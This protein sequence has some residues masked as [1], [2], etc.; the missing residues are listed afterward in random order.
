MSETGAE[1]RFR[2][3]ADLAP[4]AIFVLA[5]GRFVYANPAAV[6]A[7]GY[8]AVDELLAIQPSDC[9]APDA[10]AALTTRIDCVKRGALGLRD[11]MARRKDG[12]TMIMEISSSI[13]ELEGLEAVLAFG[14]DVTERRMLEVRVEQ[15]DRLATIGTLAAGVAHEINNPLAYVLLHLQRLARLLPEALAVTE[16]DAL[17]RSVNDAIEGTMR[18]SRIVHDLL[19]FSR[20]ADDRE[21]LVDLVAVC[22][23]TRKLVECTAAREMRVST[24]YQGC[25]MVRANETK[26][27][28]VVLN[29][30]LN[31]AHAVRGRVEPEVRIVARVA[32]ERAVIEIADNGPGI[33]EP[34][35]ERIFSPFVTTKASGSG[36]GLGLTISRNIVGALGGTVRAANRAEGGAVL[37]VELPQAEA[38]GA[39]RS[40]LAVA[41]PA[42]RRG[43]VMVIDDERVLASALAGLLHDQHDVEVHTDPMRALEAL[44]NDRQPFDL[45]LCDLLMP[46]LSG[47]SLYHRL[48]QSRPEHAA[49][50][51]FMTGGMLDDE[52]RSTITNGDIPLLQKPF[53]IEHVLALVRGRVNGV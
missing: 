47:T 37:R 40:T 15:Q 6:R 5:R 12:S 4:D 24:D 20:Q 25:P 30:L 43:R 19:T 3:I 18:V 53:E 7:L 14:R 28:Q 2:E 27:G 13:I 29:L 44:E 1:A 50:F 48:K 32:G 39:A 21:T 8:G 17:L 45:V 35:L 9:F 41:E 36:T 16:R 38:R 10:L 51:T 23:S 11:T 42:Q 34:D 31:A 26:L 46:Q 52:Q 22:E 49:C 33:P